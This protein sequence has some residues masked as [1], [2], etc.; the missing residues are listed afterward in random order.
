[1]PVSTSISKHIQTHIHSRTRSDC[2]VTFIDTKVNRRLA[3]LNRETQT[4]HKPVPRRYLAGLSFGSSSSVLAQVLDGKTQ[5]HASKK[6]S[7]AFDCHVV[8][9]DT[10]L[11]SPEP[12]A[13]EITPAQRLLAKY[14]EK[15]PRITFECV[16]LSKVLEVKTVDWA[17]LPSIEGSDN[18]ERLRN[19]FDSLPSVSS[20]ADI[21]R[22]F[23]RHLL[24]NLAIEKSYN[25]LL[26]GHS[27]TALASLTLSEVANGRGFAVPWQVNDGPYTVCTYEQRSTKDSTPS[28]EVSRTTIPVYYP[29]RETFKGEITIFVSLTPAL[30]ELVLVDNAATGSVV[31]HKDLSIEEVVGRYFETVEES[32][33]GVVANVVRITAKL[34]KAE[35]TES[36]RL[37]GMTRDELGDSRWAGELGDE[38]DEA[39]ADL[40]YGCKRSLNG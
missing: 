13:G 15:H 10:D 16:H 31:S 37:C 38:E 32:Y 24:L 25:A 3:T 14:R 35:G 34:D 29:M 30:E 22:L 7:A 21:L 9:V 18:V 36:C 19:L 28:Q 20:K 39:G 8:H 26:L 17:A 1:M 2:Y 27:T 5:Y 23:I 40:C 4:T 6:G 11:N 33:S 12:T